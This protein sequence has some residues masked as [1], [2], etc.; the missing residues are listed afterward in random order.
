MSRFDP[1]LQN[2]TNLQKKTLDLSID[3]LVEKERGALRS[4]WGTSKSLRLKEDLRW[5][6]ISDTTAKY[7]AAKLVEKES[8]EHPWG[9]KWQEYFA[10]HGADTS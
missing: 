2:D 5:T 9:D 8:T 10:Q 3:L 6:I 4:V 1:H 7:W